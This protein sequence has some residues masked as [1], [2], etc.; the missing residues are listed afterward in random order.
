MLNDKLLITMTLIKYNPFDYRPVSFRNFMDRFF[1]DA[2]F[3]GK[4]LADFSPK[5]DIAESDKNFEI[6]FHLPGVK[7]DEVSINVDDNTLTVSGERKMENEKKEKNFHSVE[8]YFG[9]F[10]R[11]FHLPENVN[12]DKIDA[13]FKDGILTVTL[14][15]DATKE[16]KRTIAIK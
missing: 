7:K 6:Q 2:S 14:P 11:S 10:S 9:T 3:G 8:S 5:V 13:A 16:I 15:K 4:A 12:V 1:D